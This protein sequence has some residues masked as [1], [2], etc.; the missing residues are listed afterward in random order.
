MQIKINLQIFI[1]IIIF[2][3]THQIAIY[4]LLMLFAFIHEMGHLIT[5]MMLGL[6]PK[7]LHI[8]PF[9][10]TVVFET[11]TKQK[12]IIEIKKIAIAL[13]RTTCKFAYNTNCC[14]YR[15]RI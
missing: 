8:V 14:T 11:Y 9:G 2:I 6:K 15:D 7:S 5:G 3:A 13:A 1:F 10:L 4:S 12:K